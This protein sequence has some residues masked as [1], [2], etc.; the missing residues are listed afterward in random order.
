[1]LPVATAPRVGK[2][3][4][5]VMRV[6]LLLVVAAGVLHRH[7]RLLLSVA[8]DTPALK[9]A[10]LQDACRQV[11]V[12][13]ARR[14]AP[15]A[16]HRGRRVHP[17]R[18]RVAPEAEGRSLTSS[19]RTACVGGRQARVPRH[20]RELQALGRGR[21]VREQP[22]IHAPQLPQVVRLVHGRGEAPEAVPPHGG[23]E[24]AAAGGRRGPHLSDAPPRAEPELR[25]QGALA[26]ARPVDRHD[27]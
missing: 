14:C 6:G 1:M 27:R 20:Q 7:V 18:R 4:Q 16:L 21:R 26:A 25:R 10:N 15:A 3:R 24:A 23:R 8:P 19:A 11:K 2:K 12:A 22:G 9:L 13:A 17:A 5:P